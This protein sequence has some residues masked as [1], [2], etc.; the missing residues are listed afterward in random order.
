M[1]VIMRPPRMR[2]RVIAKFAVAPMA[3][4]MTDTITAMNT[5]A[6]SCCQKYCTRLWFAPSTISK[7]WRVGFLGK[8][9]LATASWA[10]ESAMMN[11]W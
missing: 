10:G 9:P 1:L 2:M 4:V 5:L 11:R 7:F 8:S 6:P 3:S